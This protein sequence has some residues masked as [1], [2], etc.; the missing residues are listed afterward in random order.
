MWASG[1]RLALPGPHVVITSASLE[2]VEAYGGE[3]SMTALTTIYIYAEWVDL[4]SSV[5]IINFMHFLREANKSAHDSQKK[6]AHELAKS[7]FNSR[8]CCN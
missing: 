3:V 6:F 4:V 8:V 2:T 5:G 7:C 1:S